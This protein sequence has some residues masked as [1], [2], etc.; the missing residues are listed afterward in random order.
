MSSLI[1]PFVEGYWVTLSFLLN[2]SQ[3]VQQ[4]DMLGHKI[5]Y[6]AETLFDEG[7]LSL[8]ESCSFETILN[9]IDK[10]ISMGILK[11]TSQYNVKKD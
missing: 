8:Y 6:L 2:M 4:F 7:Y 10:F 5:Q 1:T 3:E 9:S 11:V